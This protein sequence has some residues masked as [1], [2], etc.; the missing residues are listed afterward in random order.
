M[1]ALKNSGR[2]G[3]PDT[4][5]LAPKRATLASKVTAAA[6]TTRARSR[7]VRPGAAFCSITSV[8]IPRSAARATT[9]P[10][11]YPPTPTTT[12]GRLLVMTCQASQALTGK[13][14][15]PRAIAASD[16]PFRPALRITSR[17][18]RSRGTTV[19]SMPAAV[20]TNATCTSAARLVSAL[21]TAMPG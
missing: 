11:L 17:G 21:A 19:D 4:K 18:K 3:L 14:A 7:L 15:S 1:G 10:E 2:T 9:G 20:P 16:L 6:R 8:G 13:S 5:A 12:W